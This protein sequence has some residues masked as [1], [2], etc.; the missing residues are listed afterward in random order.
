MWHLDP[1]NV[2]KCIGKNNYL[3]LNCD[4]WIWYR[5]SCTDDR[6]TVIRA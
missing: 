1:S 3:L 2:Y 4:K 5:S 6:H